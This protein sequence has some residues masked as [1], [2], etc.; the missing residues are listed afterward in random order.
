M[1][2]A[3]EVPCEA[4]PEMECALGR[5]AGWIGQSKVGTDRQ[6]EIACIHW[7]PMSMHKPWR[8]VRLHL[9]WDAPEGSRPAGWDGPK[10]GLIQLAKEAGIPGGSYRLI[11]EPDIGW[12]LEIRK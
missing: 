8:H 4:A 2:E 1:R 12:W 10:D 11:I 6:V 9:R 7:K 3:R 5:Q